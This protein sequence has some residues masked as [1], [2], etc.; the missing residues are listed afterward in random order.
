LINSSV[1]NIFSVSTPL[2]NVSVTA[3]TSRL[4]GTLVASQRLG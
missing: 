4:L 3:L 1:A 2:R